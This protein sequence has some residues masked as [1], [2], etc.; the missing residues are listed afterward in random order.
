[1]W[2]PSQFL[3]KKRKKLGVII[4][5]FDYKYELS[6]CSVVGGLSYNAGIF[7]VRQKLP[8]KQNLVRTLHRKRIKTLPIK[9]C[10]LR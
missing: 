6:K 5:E 3:D 10:C 2:T 4:K 7:D 1:M 9:K 8:E